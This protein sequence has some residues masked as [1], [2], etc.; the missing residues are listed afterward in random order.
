V[1]CEQREYAWQVVGSSPDFD[2]ANKQGRKRASGE[3][4][5]KRNTAG[6]RC[7]DLL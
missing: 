7:L 2:H 3:S 6:Q 5:T 4:I 1:V